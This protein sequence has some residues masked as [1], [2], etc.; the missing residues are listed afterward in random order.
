[1][2]RALRLF[3]VSLFATACLH[4]QTLTGV[5][6][7]SVIDSGGL[8]VAGAKGKL[9][10]IAT[11]EQR[12]FSTDGVGLFVLT[13]V[14]PGEYSISI[15]VAGFKRFEK[16][17]LVLTQAERLVVGKLQLEVG[18]LTESVTVVS[19][20]AA[21]EVESSDRTQM[22]TGEQMN[23]MQSRGRNYLSLL[24]TLPGMV[25]DDRFFETDAFQLTLTPNVNGIAAGGNSV[26]VD[27]GSGASAINP[28][29]S[30]SQVAMD[31]VAEVKVSTANYRAEDGRNGGAIIKTITKSGS[32]DYKGTAYYYFRNE[33]LNANAYIN[34]VNNVA[35]AKYRFNTFGA[36]LGGPLYVPGKVNSKKDKLFFFVSSDIGPTKYPRPLVQVTMPTTLERAGD[37]SQTVDQNNRQVPI[38]DP[39]NNRVPF[40]NNV[41]PKDRLNPRGQAL[42]SLFPDANFTNRAISGGNYNYNFSDTQ[43]HN[44]YLNMVKVD[45]APTSKLRMFAR[46][47]FWTV[48]DPSYFSG[49]QGWNMLKASNAER[50]LNTNL[51]SSYTFSPTMV[52]ELNLSYRRQYFRQAIIDDPSRLSRAKLGVPLAQFYPGNNPNNFVPAMS[53]GGVPGAAALTPR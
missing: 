15:E 26:Y 18:A 48:N 45:Y 4:A 41:I 36:T 35:R 27:G 13:A 12:P 42:L 25:G 23:T 29:Y 7:G 50:A 43:Y 19:Q 9:L 14:Q 44:T 3:A 47:S 21:V 22:I 39:T 2:F 6:S 24:N 17:G 46:A 40:P 51:N 30:Y 38:W 33:A 11:G 32:R 31:S 49:G 53:F 10:Q 16:T 28:N 20:G 52:N 1:M 34:K 8:A 37:F 5:I